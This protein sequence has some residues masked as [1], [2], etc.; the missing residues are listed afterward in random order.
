M[1]RTSDSRDTRWRYADVEVRADDPASGA[2][3]HEI[4]LLVAARDNFEE[5]L[6]FVSANAGA[7]SEPLRKAR[8]RLRVLKRIELN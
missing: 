5:Y 1:L 2:I 8:E 4:N 3:L 7:S 6:D